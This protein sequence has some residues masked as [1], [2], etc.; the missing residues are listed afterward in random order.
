MVHGVLVL[1]VF[2]SSNYNVFR[3]DLHCRYCIKI[4]LRSDERVL[5]C[6][7]QKSLLLNYLDLSKQA[8]TP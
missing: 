4:E 7:S 1:S 5:F 6:F 8:G 3:S 2:V